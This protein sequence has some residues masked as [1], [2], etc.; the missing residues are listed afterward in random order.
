MK[1]AKITTY[2]PEQPATLIF[3]EVETNNGLI[4]LGET[5]FGAETV[6]AE[7]H[8]RL[9]QSLLGQDACKITRLTRDTRPYVGAC[10][11]GAEMRASSAIEIALWDLAGKR[12]QA[13][14]V[15]LLGG[16]VR[17]G[18]PVYNTCAGQDYVSNSS[19]VRPDNFGQETGEKF[20]DLKAF[21]ERPVEL[22]ESLLAMGISSMKIW[23][24]DFASGARD[25]E[26]ISGPDLK[27]A[28]E[29]FEAIRAALGDRM[30][31]KAELHGLWSLTAALKICRALEP[32]A[33]DWVE[34]PVRMDRPDQLAE[35]VAQTDCPIAGGETLGG[36][37][38]VQGLLASGIQYPI[39]DVTWGG[40][41][42]FAR[43]AAALAGAKGRP[44]AF[45]D[46]SG[47]V[48]LAVSTHL[49]HALPLV[50]EQEITRAFYTHVYPRLVH[51]LPSLKNGALML[52]DAPG[53]GVKL[54]TALRSH[55][56]TK[57]RL[58]AKS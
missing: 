19:D 5:W 46:C 40:G 25:G 27:R 49:A 28:L 23:P 6:E 13:P 4:G 20:E 7:I 16:S 22:A 9:S 38:Q 56:R 47:P 32:L 50:R 17:A 18:I 36:V 48:T 8:G 26:D 51:G 1:I 35:L 14:L 10:G 11:T 24:F 39:V 21:M 58:S 52:S 55:P 42:E 12:F 54:T 29:P 30:A 57:V 53:H 41:I 2:R 31:L 44:I 37:G 34:D 33:P 3:V 15:E 43:E 45:H